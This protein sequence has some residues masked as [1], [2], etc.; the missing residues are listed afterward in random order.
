M[1]ARFAGF[2]VWGETGE[3]GFE[4]VELLVADRVVAALGG[5]DARAFEHV[6]VEA[7]DRDEWG[8]EGEVDAG[9]GHRRADE[10][11]GVG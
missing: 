8:V 9:L 3:F 10:G 11:A 1:T 4:E 5:D 6:C 7:D 2:A